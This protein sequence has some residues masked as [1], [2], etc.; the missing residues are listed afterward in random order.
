MNTKV[1]KM[2]AS[3]HSCGMKAAKFFLALFKKKRE[4]VTNRKIKKVRNYSHRNDYKWI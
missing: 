3:G 2:K 1:L 4:D